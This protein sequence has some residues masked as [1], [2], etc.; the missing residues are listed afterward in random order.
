[1]PIRTRNGNEEIIVEQRLNVES[2]AKA[3]DELWEKNEAVNILNQKVR[4]P[5]A[6]QSSISSGQH[7]LAE[8]SFHLETS[9]DLD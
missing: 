6:S 8:S 9:K 5:C 7:A 3:F 4:I 2:I 1:M